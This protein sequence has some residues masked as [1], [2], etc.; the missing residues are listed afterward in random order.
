MPQ[1]DPDA[2]ITGLTL[3]I[4]SWASSIERTRSST[5]LDVVSN[6]ARNKLIDALNKLQDKVSEMLTA[7]K[8]D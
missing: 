2:E 6:T 3:T 7:I 5:N 1:Y 4:P 8:E